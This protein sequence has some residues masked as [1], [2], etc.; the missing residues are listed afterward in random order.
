M[1][2]KYHYD[3]NFTQEPKEY[4]D[5]LLYQLGEMMC[6]AANIVDSTPT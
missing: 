6:N 1:K 4:G 5:L 3:N 2:T